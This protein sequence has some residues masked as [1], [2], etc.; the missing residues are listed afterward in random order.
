LNKKT[1]FIFLLGVLFSALIFGLLSWLAPKPAAQ[2]KG[3]DAKSAAIPVKPAA[4]VSTVSPKP[5]SIPPLETP[6][7][8]ALFLP[9]ADAHSVIHEVKSGE[10]LTQI[11][12]KY[13]VT[14]ELIQ[15]VNRLTGDRLSVGM[16]LKIPTYKFSVVTDK[17]Q[18]TL[19]LKG[20]EEVL[21]TYV[22]STGENNSTPV[23]VFQ[24]TDRLID[25]TWYKAGAVVPPGS[26]ENVLGTRWLGFT[27]KG[28]GIHGTTEPEKLGRQVTAGCVR[29][30]N[31][32]VED[33]FAFLPAGSEVTIVD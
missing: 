16:K 14:I 12:K 18:N 19:I 10:N 6:A 2:T 8:K 25:P 23:G 4:P 32:E 3:I 13:R 28:Y 31:E 21:K 17:S 30:R 27:K 11:S 7:F 24:I 26:S 29:M 20:D 5:S 1:I 9:G 15:R 22:V 33:L